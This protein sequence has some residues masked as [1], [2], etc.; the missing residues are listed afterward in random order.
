MRTLKD[1][2]I[3]KN[4]SQYRF[5]LEKDHRPKMVK[6]GIPQEVADHLHQIDDK[7][8]IWF[9]NQFKG[10][11]GFQ[12][13]R[14]KVNWI[15]VNHAEDITSILDWVRGA[16]NIIL[17]DYN[18][19]DALNASHEWHESLTKSEETL[20]KEIELEDSD[21][22]ILKVYSDGYYWIDLETT[23]SRKESECMGHCGRTSKGDT[24]WSLR[25]RT[26][27]YNK[28]TAKNCNSYVTMS[29]SPRDGEWHQCKGKGN[30]KPVEEYYSYIADILI[31]NDILSYTS[32]YRSQDDFNA[33]TLK[34][35]VDDNHTKFE[36]YN[37]IIEKIQESTIS[38][39]KFQEVVD[40]AGLSY[41]G[42]WV[43]DVGEDDYVYYSESFDFT[44][45]TDDERLNFEK[46][47][48]KFK[49]ESTKM[50]EYQYQRE[51]YKEY[52]SDIFEKYDVYMSDIE[53]EIE[54]KFISFRI[55]I[56][57]SES[58]S[59]T[60]DSLN[61]FERYVNY[62]KDLDDKFK[63]AVEDGDIENEILNVFKRTGLVETNYRKLFDEFNKNH[64]VYKNLGEMKQEEDGDK[65][66]LV[67]KPFGGSI[68]ES[69][70]KHANKIGEM[71]T[72]NKADFS[73]KGEFHGFRFHNK[74]D[75]IFSYTK[76]PI[77]N[78]LYEFLNADIF[79]QY[80][81]EAY[82]DYLCSIRK[83]GFIFRLK[84][85]LD[86]DDDVYKN[87]ENIIKQ[88]EEFDDNFNRLEEEFE[89]YGNEVVI[90][91]AESIK[92]LDFSG[93]YYDEELLKNQYDKD[94]KYFSIDVPIYRKSDDSEVFKDK[95][96]YYDFENHE[97]K[98]FREL[99]AEFDEK[100]RKRLDDIVYN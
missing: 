12:N 45:K 1:I 70:L 77:F 50:Q 58:F 27:R 62:V 15:N 24:L 40:N 89:K 30:Q 72:L 33:N 69:L 21:G 80:F 43:D 64:Q 100:I 57:S 14:D 63:D 95:F 97:N 59:L 98:S 79:V 65:F 96:S 5:L 53:M 19:E 6:F 39:D 36:N 78:M 60:E 55:S 92:R 86:V 32:E 68:L 51:F 9:A 8:S 74:S 47:F 52:F 28:G 99:K 81:G 75:G 84:F 91:K 46:L 31:D 71:E 66:E 48:E 13:A 67:F 11:E 38:I 73:D 3:S 76:Y 16:T 44:F 29:V 56:E 83:N 85:S 93:V 35:Y 49:S 54:E 87:T 42:L 7:Y 90:P 10:M 2:L 88:I 34:Q 94:T 20:A 82:F 37:E 18:W 17:K 22:E 26:K 41:F 23:Y 61:S 25:H 4:P